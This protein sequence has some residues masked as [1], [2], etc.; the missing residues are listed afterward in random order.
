MTQVVPAQNES[1]VAALAAPPALQDA[2]VAGGVVRRAPDLVEVAVVGAVERSY[3]AVG[4]DA[5]GAA[6]GVDVAWTR[7]G[8]R[9]A[10]VVR[11]RRRVPLLVALAVAVPEDDRRAVG[12]PGAVGVEAP[13]GLHTGDR[14]VGVDVPLLV[15][16]AVAVPDDDGGA[17]GGALP[18]GVQA[19]VAVHHQLFARRVGPGL[20]RRT[21]AVPQLRLGA[22][23]GARDVQ[24]ASG[25]AAHDRGALPGLD[26]C[27]H[28]GA[29][30]EEQKEGGAQ[31]GQS[32]AV[33]EDH[34]GH[35]TSL[36]IGAGH[37]LATSRHRLS[38]L[39]L[40]GP[41]RPARPRRSSR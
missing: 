12:R 5:R 28:G 15:G 34:C 21:G 37:A 41:G 38:A 1:W 10:G 23:A 31:Q 6:G 36:A 24:A 26:G 16:L 19:L 30:D 27:R 13:A 2:D 7:A 14:A 20:V 22:V 32:P 18:V 25:L 29:S 3:G 40:S 4:G 35:L 33:N 8:R 11:G 39:P 17:V 9:P